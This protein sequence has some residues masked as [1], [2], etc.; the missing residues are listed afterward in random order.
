[1]YL[2]R[3]QHQLI[4]A[5]AFALVEIA[6]VEIAAGSAETKDQCSHVLSIGAVLLPPKNGRDKEL[7]D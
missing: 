4:A 6:A 5:T 2:E 3:S 1:M 7:R